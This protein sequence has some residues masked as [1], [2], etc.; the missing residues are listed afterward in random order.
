MGRIWFPDG[1]PLDVRVEAAIAAPRER[2]AAYASDPLNDPDWISGIRSAEWL[3]EPPLREGS[4]VE[5]LAGFLGRR[6]EYVLEVVELRP[7]RLVKMRSVRAPFPMEVTY[8]FDDDPAGCL[9]SIR[10]RG[11][12]GLVFRVARPLMAWR[13]RRS[14][15]MDLRNLA[16][17]VGP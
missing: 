3:S 8:G 4:R 10:V 7:G 15:R 5:R 16:A 6:I 13:V 11:G 17:R 9:A 14:L 2:V 12:E 1:P